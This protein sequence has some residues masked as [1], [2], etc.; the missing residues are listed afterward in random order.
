VNRATGTQ[1]QAAVTTPERFS[2]NGWA[3]QLQVKVDGAYAELYCTSAA[4]GEAVVVGRLRLSCDHDHE[5]GKP[6][7]RDCVNIAFSAT[8]IALVVQHWH[9]RR[10]L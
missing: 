2:E 1:A 7:A 3:V 10:E 6:G 9:W 4:T 8:S 5:S